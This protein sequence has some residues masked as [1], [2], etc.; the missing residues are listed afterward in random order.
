MTPGVDP[1]DDWSGATLSRDDRTLV[2]PSPS[3]PCARAAALPASLS[4]PP[5]CGLGFCPRLP[6]SDLCR[7]NERNRPALYSTRGLFRV[8]LPCKSPQLR[9]RLRASP[10]AGSRRRWLAALMRCCYCSSYGYCASYCYSYGG[11]NSYCCMS[12]LPLLLPLQLL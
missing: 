4:L 8:L 6:L 3:S 11:R 7:T 1:G 5:S 12:M 2:R 9:A 10:G